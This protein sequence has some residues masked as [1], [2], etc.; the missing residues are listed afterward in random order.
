MLEWFRRLMPREHRFFDLFNRHAELTVT[1]A[2]ALKGLLAGTD[3]EQSCREIVRLEHE[4]DAV[5]RDVLLALRRTF[6]TPFDRGDI[7]DLIT[8]MDDAVD[9]MQKAAKTIIRFDRTDFDPAMGEVGG[10]IVEASGLVAEAVALLDH[11][12]ANVDRLGA[13]TEQVKRVEER[14]DTIHDDAL[15]SL[16]QGTPAGEAMNYVIGEEIYEHLE[17]VVD[18][19]D[20]VAN[21][22]NGIVLESV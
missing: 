18:R 16:F 17:V 8:A 20:D 15:R 10:A 6:I 3:I 5:T 13:L 9:A 19:L 21:Q 2:A 14:A 7:R 11:I 22:I 4:A 1:C 12:P